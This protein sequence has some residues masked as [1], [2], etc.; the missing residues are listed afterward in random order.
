MTYTPGPWTILDRV[1]PAA[2]IS[3]GVGRPLVADHINGADA[4]LLVNAPERLIA[5][6]VAVSLL[7]LLLK[8]SAQERRSCQ[9][10]D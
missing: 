7:D 9:W 10:C 1:T 3:A 6:R 5:L 4:A 2:R 8:V